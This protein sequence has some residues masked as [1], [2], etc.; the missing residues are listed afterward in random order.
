MIEGVL[1]PLRQGRFVRRTGHSLTAGKVVAYILTGAPTPFVIS[2]SRDNIEI[3]GKLAFAVEGIEVLRDVLDR[4]R[5]H[6]EHLKSFAVGEPQTVLDEATLY[7]EG[8]SDM[9]GVGG[10]IKVQ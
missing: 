10:D 4:A 1:N 7:N 5:K 2:V 8:H 9:V 6:H 3:Q